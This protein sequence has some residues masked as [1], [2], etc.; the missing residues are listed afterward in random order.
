MARPHL[1]LSTEFGAVIIDPSEDDIVDVMAAL[2]P[3]DGPAFAILAEDQ[4]YGDYVQAAGGPDPETGQPRYC[5]ERRRY[6]RDDR[7]VIVSPDRYDHFAAC[8]RDEARPLGRTYIT[9]NGFQV[10]VRTDEVLLLEDAIDVF[11][12]F[13]ESRDLPKQFTWRS[14]RA[15]VDRIGEIGRQ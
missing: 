10:N 11:N 7:G 14:N 2:K 5:I 9:T 1:R 4:D 3:G 6:E 15:D 12:Q 8:I 13:V